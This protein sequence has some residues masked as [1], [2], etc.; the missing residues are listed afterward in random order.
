MQE[1]VDF[2]LKFWEPDIFPTKL[3]LQF[4]QFILKLNPLL[5]F[6]IKIMF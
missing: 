5:P 3:I 6:I 2:E 1:I 4:D